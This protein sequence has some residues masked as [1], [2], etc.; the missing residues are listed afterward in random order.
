V[1]VDVRAVSSVADDGGAGATGSDNGAAASARLGRLSMACAVA[2]IVPIVVATVRAIGRGWVAVGDNAFFALRAGDVATEHHPW[3]GTWTSASLSLGTHINNPGP[4]YFDA[5]AIPVKVG[6]DAGLA[7]GAALVNIASVLG[8]AVVARR[9]AGP[10]AVLVA[11]A[12]AAGLGW[13]MGSELLFDPWQPNSLLFPVLCFAVM[14]WALTCGD[15]AVLPWAVGVGSFIV[16]TH[17]G[18]ALLVPA[19]GAWGVGVA[20]VRLWRARRRGDEE[21]TRREGRLGRAV[22]VTAVVA[23]VSWSQSLWEQFVTRDFGGNL[24]RLADSAGASKESVGLDLAPR[25]VAARTA[26]PPWWGRPSMSRAAGGTEV[27]P[28]LTAS[29]VGLVVVAALLVAAVVVG[30]R[31]GDAPGTMAAATGLVAIG[32]A[33]VAATTMPIGVFGVVAAHHVLWLWPL[34]VFVTFSLALA[35]VRSIGR[36]RPGRAVPAV[37]AA[38]TMALAVL[39]LPAMN[40]GSGP[41]AD[42]EAIA[43]VREL[44]AQMESLRSEPRVLVDLR[45]QR[46]AEPYS[47]PFMFELARLGVPWSVEDEGTLHQVGA[48]R[49]YGEGASVRLFLREG[50][51]ARQVPPGSRRVAFV[52]GLTDGEAAELEAIK[53]ELR[54]FID[55]GG[56]ALADNAESGRGAD[57]RSPAALSPDTLRD[58]DGLFASRSLMPYVRNDLL[59]VPEPWAE[60]LDRYAALQHRAD[61]LTVAVFAEPL[62]GP[63]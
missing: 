46:F 37:I 38:V 6:G 56:L 32:L 40:A 39:N 14:V 19:L 11:M 16:Q 41:S 25:L 35:V 59:A 47:A 3:L 27:L 2:A 9:V 33:L 30:R 43:T 45:G 57:E 52:E 49:R 5:L 13:A 36:G 62:E 17:L 12:A 18:Y 48:G 63:D 29:W 20:G 4:L 42:A 28:S 1:T 44:R 58:A 34:A 10:Q 51:L 21:W 53:A 50:D 8:I 15:L 55:D 26:L 61:Y 7:V 22:L 31:R 23:V 60:R 24:G 54:P